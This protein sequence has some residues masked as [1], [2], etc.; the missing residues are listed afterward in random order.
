VLDPICVQAE[1][2]KLTSDLFSELTQGANLLLQGRAG[3]Q[4]LE[5]QGISD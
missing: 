1:D 5:G 4:E 2:F 3:L